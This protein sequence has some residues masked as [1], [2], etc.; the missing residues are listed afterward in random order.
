M[1][2]PDCLEC[3]DPLGIFLSDLHYFPEASLSDNLKQIKRLDCEWFIAQLLK[4]N[5]EME[6]A[7]AVGS[8]VPLICGMLK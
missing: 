4:I 7:R 3:V 5:F 8:C 6:R 1:S 2:L